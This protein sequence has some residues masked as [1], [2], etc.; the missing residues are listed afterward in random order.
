M[1]DFMEQHPRRY[2]IGMVLNTNVL[3]AVFSIIS[4]ASN[5]SVGRSERRNVQRGSSVSE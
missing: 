1:A 5:R 3:D 4:T 2:E